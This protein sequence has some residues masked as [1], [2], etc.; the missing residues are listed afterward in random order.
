[1]RR[2][3]L[4]SLTR[5]WPLK[6]AALALSVLVW[7]VVSAEQV[8]TQWIPVRVDPVVRDPQFVLTGSPEPQEVRVQF[9][10]PGREL[11]ELALDRPV[12]VLP[13]RQVGEGRTF[14]LDPAMVRIP[15]GLSVNAR[16]VRPSVIALG[17]QRLASRVVPIHARISGR[18]LQRY[19]IGDSLTIIPAEVRVTGRA[20]QV[21]A[22]NVLS[23]IAFEI[24]PDDSTF[25][26]EIALDTAALDG[27][28]LSRARVRVSGTVD[29]RATRA[30][31]PVTV[32]V[33]DGL[34]AAPAQ[35]EVRLSGAERALAG[36]DP[37]RLRAVVVRDSL[38]A[39]IP[40][41]GVEARLLIEGAPAGA[42]VTANPA[43]VRVFEPAAAPSASP[44]S[45]AT[46][47]S[48][49]GARP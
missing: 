8:T 19:V 39:V 3:T 32:Y 43:R 4:R 41:G 6:L 25:T 5:N 45:P 42:A 2:V 11:W 14:A 12:L 26:R 37:A 46:M 15:Q 44:A 18:S 9:T 10:G 29:R 20:D 31:S 21:A 16:D 13:I 27:L 30:V 40:P 7:A 49:A 36:V 28:S 34:V 48:A 23:T 35:V 17:L 24:V 38:P 33:P 1:M 22:L 47:D